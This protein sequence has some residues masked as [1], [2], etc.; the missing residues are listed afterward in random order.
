MYAIAKYFTVTERR[1]AVRAGYT[2][3]TLSGPRTEDGFCPLGVALRRHDPFVQ[4][5]APGESSV[6]I[7]LGVEFEDPQFV[8]I[9]K[10]AR[11]FIKDWDNQ[12]IRN[13]ATALGVKV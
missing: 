7:S 6:A 4:T 2:S 3:R 9:C 5:W 12:R 8:P 10:A 13:L 11:R 1:A